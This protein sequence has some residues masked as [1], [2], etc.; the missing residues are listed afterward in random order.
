MK[1]FLTA[2]RRPGARTST[3]DRAGLD[4]AALN[5]QGKLGNP[6]LDNT[7]APGSTFFLGW[8]ACLPPP[9]SPPE[10]V[11]RGPAGA[12][13]RSLG[14]QTLRPPPTAAS[15]S[16]FTPA[17]LAFVLE[18]VGAIQQRTSDTCSWRT[19]PWL[20]LSLCQLRPLR[21]VPET[22]RVREWRGVGGLRAQGSPPQCEAGTGA[23]ASLSAWG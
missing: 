18:S 9:G 12:V 15:G 19:F 2:A 7:E 11:P 3:A 17:A 4:G 6:H 8:P 16:L 20:P 1:T 22:H 5:P 13:P 23:L 10:A 21:G 14:L